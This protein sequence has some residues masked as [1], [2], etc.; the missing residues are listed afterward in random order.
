MVLKIGDVVFYKTSTPIGA[1]IRKVTNYEYS[2]VAVIVDFDPSGTPMCIESLAF[3]KSNLRPLLDDKNIVKLHVMRP[4]DIDDEQRAY[5][6]AHYPEYLDI[7]YDHLG[8]VLLGLGLLF[9][10]RKRKYE[11]RKRAS[12]AWCSAIVDELMFKAGIDLVPTTLSHNVDI[13]SLAD[14]GRMYHVL[15]ITDQR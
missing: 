1:L 6:K 15:D 8:V 5:I 9:P 14:H 12:S 11:L 13:K 2:H 4:Y 10:T 7:R 3:K